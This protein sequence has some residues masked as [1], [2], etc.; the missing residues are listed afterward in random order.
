MKVLWFA[1][2]PV[3]LLQPLPVRY[4]PGR[5]EHPAP[6]VVNLS[7][8]IV[9]N[10]PEIDL[11]IATGTPEISRSI[12]MRKNGVIHHLCKTQYRLPFGRH[13]PPFEWNIFTRLQH[14]RALLCTVAQQVSPDVILA[15]GTEAAYAVA[16]KDSG[17]P[18]LIYMQGIIQELTK[19]FPEN[20]KFAIRVPLER[21]ALGDCRYYVAETEYAA[22]YVRKTVKD[23]VI[24]RGANSVTE[25]FFNVHKKPEIYNRLLFVGSLI[26][27]K[28]IEELL[29]AVAANGWPV[30]IVGQNIA[31]YPRALME[32]YQ[33]NPDI[34]WTG[35]IPTEEIAQLMGVHDALVLPSYMDTSPYV[36]AE[37]MAAGLPVVA[38]RVGG[39]P[40]MVADGVT[41]ILVESKNIESL[42][43]GIRKLYADPE[44]LLVMGAKAKQVALDRFSPRRNAAIL[45]DA[46]Q[47]VIKAKRLD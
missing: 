1:P 25:L 13:W 38:T 40:D 42:S 44:K 15:F 20:R 33:H 47:K 3:S 10:Y 28:G 31:D 29:A 43:E 12:S 9:E 2:Y 19:A 39:I 41:G 6:W 14:Q 27:T 36:V 35:K 4:K 8:A 30:T 46:F 21:E 18:Y 5:S 22:E 17:T 45:V 34:R 37:A 24:W 16:A 7:K 11:H 26:P 32:K 23:S